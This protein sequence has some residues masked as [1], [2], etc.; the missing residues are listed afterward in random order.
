MFFSD[1]QWF[2]AKWKQWRWSWWQ[3]R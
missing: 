2:G 3:W 1:M